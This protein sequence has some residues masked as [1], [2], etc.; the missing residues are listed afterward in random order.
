MYLSYFLFSCEEL[1]E[2]I[3]SVPVRTSEASLSVLLLHLL[4]EWLV[5]K[6]TASFWVLMRAL[7]DYDMNGLAGKEP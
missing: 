6:D 7:R 5:R 4:K 3:K 1:E 2:T